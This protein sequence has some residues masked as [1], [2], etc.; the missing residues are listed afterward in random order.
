[1]AIQDIIRAMSNNQNPLRLRKRHGSGRPSDATVED[2]AHLVRTQSVPQSVLAGTVVIF[3]F[4][5]VW[6]A[7]S[8]VADR[9]FPWM[10]VVLGLILGHVVRIAGRGVDWRFPAVA[11]LLSVLGSLLGNVAVAASVSAE[12]L[13]VGTLEVLRSVTNMTWGVFIDEYLTFADLVFALI[14]AAVAAF[15]ASRR[16]SRAQYR[17]LRL[18][19]QGQG[20]T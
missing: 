20:K 2:G 17:A 10:T 3:L 11:A 6:I 14:A 5:V 12:R 9:I 16:L 1:M 4:S 18:W 19:K 7:L 15:Y 8:A 13:G